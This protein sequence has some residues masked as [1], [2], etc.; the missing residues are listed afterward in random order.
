M[1][2]CGLI[3]N[4]LIYFSMSVLIFLFVL[5]VTVINCYFLHILVY[6]QVGE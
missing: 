3:I 1:W 2:T 5:F 6:H 4:E